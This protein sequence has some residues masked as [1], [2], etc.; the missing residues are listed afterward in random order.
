MHHA[1]DAQG[2]IAGGVHDEFPGQGI[3]GGGLRGHQLGGERLA[4][5]EPL[6]Q[7]TAAAGAEGFA[8]PLGQRRCTG[9]GLEVSTLSAAALPGVVGRKITMWP[10][11]LLWTPPPLAARSPMMIPLPIPLPSVNS[12]RLRNGRPA[13]SQASP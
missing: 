8:G 12:T 4:A 11:S 5:G 7:G 3:A 1:D 9:I 13:P 10:H 2:Q 6:A